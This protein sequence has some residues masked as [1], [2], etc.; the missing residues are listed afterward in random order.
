MVVAGDVGVMRHLHPGGGG[1][2]MAPAGKLR[3]RQCHCV[4]EAVTMSWGWCKG[5]IT[6]QVSYEWPRW[7]A[8]D[9]ARNSVSLRKC[10]G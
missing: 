1:G 6:L 10:F 4:S 2:G 7:M 3:Q 8:E 9:D 5:V